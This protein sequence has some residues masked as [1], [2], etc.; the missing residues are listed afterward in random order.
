MLNFTISGLTF[1]LIDMHDNQ[2]IFT[3]CLHREKYD[4]RHDA[5]EY[6]YTVK[7]NLKGSFFQTPTSA[8]VYVDSCHHATEQ[9]VGIVD[10]SF[11]CTMEEFVEQLETNVRFN[12]FY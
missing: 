7:V 5:F 12:I 8:E 11:D 10:L 9:Q 4:K 6:I 3:N 1:R 2:L